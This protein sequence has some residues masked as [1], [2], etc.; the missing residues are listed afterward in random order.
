MFFKKKKNK[1]IEHY[2]LM[3]YA[4]TTFSIFSLALLP[5]M[6]MMENTDTPLVF[7]MSIPVMLGFLM[8]A[9]VKYL[10]LKGFSDYMQVFIALIFGYILYSIVQSLLIY[11]GAYLMVVIN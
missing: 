8:W 2:V 11:V 9:S 6:K 3:V 10:N 4:L 5:A 7:F 1:F